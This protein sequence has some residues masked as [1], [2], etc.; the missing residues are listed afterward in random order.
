MSARPTIAIAAAC[1]IAGATVIKHKPSLGW[2]LMGF[3]F[4]MAVVG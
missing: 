4:G 3:G 2:V 1:I